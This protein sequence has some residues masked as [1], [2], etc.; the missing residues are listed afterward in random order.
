VRFRLPGAGGEIDAE[1]RIAWSHQRVGMG[2]QFKQ[3]AETDNKNLTE[4]LA[5][6]D[7]QDAPP[8]SGLITK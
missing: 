7:S 3:L 2:I 6:L 4:L 5:K 1:G 8:P